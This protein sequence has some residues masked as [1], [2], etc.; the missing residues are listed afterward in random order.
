[1]H[2]VEDCLPFKGAHIPILTL[3]PHE[4][5]PRSGQRLLIVYGGS[6]KPEQRK[7]IA[8][9][10][11]ESLTSLGFIVHCF[12]FRSNI[13][14]ERFH[15]FGLHDRL[16]DTRAVYRYL[17]STSYAQNDENRFFQLPLSIM[18]VS[19]G[20]YLAARV[21][22]EFAYY[23]HALILIAPAAYHDEACKSDV[24]FGPGFKRAITHP[25]NGWR[26][27][28]AF[29]QARTIAADCLIVAYEYDEIVPREIPEAYRH[30]MHVLRNNVL[31]EHNFPD[32]VLRYEVLS[33]FKHK[34]TF[35]NPEKRKKIRQILSE[36]FSEI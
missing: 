24:T 27:C 32:Y 19:M 13:D 28:E 14:A 35:N 33:G 20:G 34:G 23:L 2:V 36:F 16:E 4:S 25:P 26:Q 10:W 5:I 31:R 1:M 15:E 6:R 9:F 12:E 17:R 29:K 22:A 3:V 18:G 8:S 7:K 11:G 21:A 30:H